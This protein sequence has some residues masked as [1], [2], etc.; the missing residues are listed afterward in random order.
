[1]GLL[2]GTAEAAYHESAGVRSGSEDSLG[3]DLRLCLPP[4]WGPG[5]PGRPDTG[6]GPA[7]VSEMRLP[8]RRPDLMA[9][10]RTETHPPSTLSLLRGLRR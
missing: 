4:M 5:G 9:A 3:N 6:E 10:A 1:M 2:A 7:A 8:V